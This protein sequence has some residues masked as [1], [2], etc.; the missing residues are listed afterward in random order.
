MD[1][2]RDTNM[3]DYHQYILDEG[4]MLKYNTHTRVRCLTRVSVQQPSR[5]ISLYTCTLSMSNVQD[6]RAGWMERG[7]TDRQRGDKGI[8]ESQ[9]DIGEQK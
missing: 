8:L 3:M 6:K 4:G 7:H 2:Q 9:A 5:F 1:W